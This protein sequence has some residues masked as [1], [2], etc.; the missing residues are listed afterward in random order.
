MFPGRNNNE[1]L[2]L[3]MKYKGKVNIKMQRKAQYVDSHFNEQGQFLSN[4]IDPVSRQV[5]IYIYI[6]I[7]I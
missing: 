2:K 7:Y 4:E 5:Y 6:Y 3:F 1:M